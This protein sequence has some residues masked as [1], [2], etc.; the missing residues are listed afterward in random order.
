MKQLNL[1]EQTEIKIKRPAKRR[2]KLLMT[3]KSLSTWKQRVYLH[4]QLIRQTRSPQQISLFAEID[5][6]SYNIDKIDPFSLPLNPSLFYE[7]P[8]QGDAVCFYFVIDNTLPLLLY[9][10]ATKQTPKKRWQEH[11]C[12]KYIMHYIQL[13]RAYDL[14]VTVGV[15]FSWDAPQQKKARLQLE[16]ELIYKWRSPFNKECWQYWGQPF[17]KT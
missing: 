13:H 1:F 14:P 6:N 3:K 9:I 8:E 11:D 7:M 4:Q 16:S 17:G 15:A 2:P 12:Q 5:N 10:G